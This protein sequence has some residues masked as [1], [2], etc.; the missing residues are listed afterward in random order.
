MTPHAE[1]MSILLE[2]IKVITREKADPIGETELFEDYGLDSLDSMNLLLELEDR[3]KCDL[4]DLDL[5]IAN[6]PNLLYTEIKKK[7]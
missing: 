5:S 4:G 2:A 3:L 1:F 6:T 7:Q